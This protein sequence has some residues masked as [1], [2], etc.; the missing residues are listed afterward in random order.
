MVG[1]EWKFEKV[2][3]T[4]IMIPIDSSNADESKASVQKVLINEET[5]EVKSVK[6]IALPLVQKLDIPS[7]RK[8]VEINL[9][10]VYI[11]R[12]IFHYLYI[13]FEI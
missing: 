2:I 6:T 12:T 1:S 4:Y 8:R 10:T 11:V 13:D 7:T 9:T 3:V 5:Y